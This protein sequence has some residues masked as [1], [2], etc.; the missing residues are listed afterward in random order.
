[1]DKNNLNNCKN[2]ADKTAYNESGEK[3]KVAP[4]KVKSAQALQNG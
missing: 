4:N 2:I 3:P 1:L